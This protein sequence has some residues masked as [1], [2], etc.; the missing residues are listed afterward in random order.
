VNSSSIK[1]VFLQ[2]G[3]DAEYLRYC[4]ENAMVMQGGMKIPEEALSNI[5]THHN[6]TSRQVHSKFCIQMGLQHLSGGHSEEH[7]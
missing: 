3:N 6:V 7:V 2:A 4:L 1:P 5:A